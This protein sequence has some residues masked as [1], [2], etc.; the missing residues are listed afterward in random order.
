MKSLKSC[1]RT[2]YHL[3]ILITNAMHHLLLL[4][5]MREKGKQKGGRGGEREQQQTMKQRRWTKGRRDIVVGLE[6]LK[7]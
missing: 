6:K 1:Y 4:D 7:E 2:L 5:N 3:S